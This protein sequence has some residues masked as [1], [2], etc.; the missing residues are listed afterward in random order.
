MHHILFLLIC[1]IWGS[2]FLLMKKA[3][4]VFG[5]ISIGAYRVLGGAVVLGV[6]WAMRGRA[7]PLKKKH[8]GPLMFIVVVGY[9]WPFTI[10]PW[11]VARHGGSFIAMMVT[12][13]PLLTILISIP[14]L[15]V[16]PTKRQL[17]G[18]I[19]GLVCMGVVFREGKV[20]LDVPLAD[21]ALAATVPLAYSLAN[22]VLKRRCADIGT[23]PLAFINLALATAILLPIGWAVEGIEPGST[24][25]A[26]SAADQQTSTAGILSQPTVMTATLCVLWLGMVGTG[27]ANYFFYK[28]VQDHGPLFASMVTYLIPTIALFWGWVDH[29]IITPLQIAGLAGTFVM[30]ALV[31]IGRSPTKTSAAEE[32]A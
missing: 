21:L 12:L 25:Q 15:G 23:L 8:I 3:M 9:A 28:L 10:Q 22:I 13:V 29:E 24:A 14:A 2:N 19:G 5:P 27:I 1:F 11:L 17:V 31:Q 6:V 26:T 18:V 20:Q 7:W 16:H 30:I 32:L 4:V